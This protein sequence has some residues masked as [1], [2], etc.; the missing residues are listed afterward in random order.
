MKQIKRTLTNNIINDNNIKNALFLVRHGECTSNLTWPI[1]DYTDEI[2]VLTDLG[3]NQIL[4]TLN[5]FNQFK[6][7][8]KIISSTLMRAKQSADIISTSISNSIVLEPDDRIVEKNQD[9]PLDFFKARIESFFQNR[10]K[11]EGPWILVIHG[12]VIET[13]LIDALRAPY[14]LIEK[15]DMSLGIPGIWGIANGSISAIIDKKFV[16]FNFVP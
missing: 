6:V 15:D 4:N 10:I 1:N 5:Y 11:N 14:A 12:H 9:E 7:T 8:F 16:F 13:L 2:D 3:K